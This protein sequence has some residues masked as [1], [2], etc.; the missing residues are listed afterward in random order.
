MKL[1]LLLSIG[2]I[3]QLNSCYAQLKGNTYQF[4]ELFGE[5]YFFN[6]DLSYK[7]LSNLKVPGFTEEQ[8]DHY[9]VKKIYNTQRDFDNNSYYLEWFE[10]EKYL[11]K[12]VDTIMPMSVKQKQPYNVFIERDIDYNAHA[13]GNG[14]VFANIG[15]LANCK[16]EAEL[17]YILSHEIGHSVFNHGYEINADLV[18]SYN[19]N[20]DAAMISSLNKIFDKSQFTELQSDSFAYKCVQK[21]S[22]NLGAARLALNIIGYSEFNSQFYI[23]KNHR[24]SYQSYMEKFSTHPS[25][26]KRYKLL[27]ANLKELKYVGKNYLID[28][29]YFNKVKKIAHEECKKISMETGDFNNSLKLAFIDYTQGDNSLKN[30]FYIFES[31]R[32]IMYLEPERSVKGFLAEDLQFSE[33]ENVNHSILKKP[34]VLFVDSMQYNKSKKHPLFTDETKPFNTY[35]EAYVYFIK[36][37][38]EKNFN[39]AFFSKALFCFSKKDDAGFK[40]NISKYLEKGGGLFTDFANNLNQFGFPYIKEGKTNI[41][42]DYS[43][44]FTVYDNY[45]H[46]LQ[47]IS[48]NKE[49]HELFK[50]DT[51]KVTLTLMSELLGTRPKLLYNYQKLKWNI[52]QLYDERDENRFYRKHYFSRDELSET[53]MKNKY[54]KNLMIYIPE[55]YKWFKENNLNGILYQKIKY[56]YLTVREP[57]EYHN[58]YSI[59]YLNFFDNRPYFGKCNRNG[60]LRKQKTTEMA[61]DA[62]EY[63]FYKE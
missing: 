42:I 21:A 51:A 38:E 15:L 24:G 16:N 44:N 37:S 2:I 3:F 8:L 35:E 20:D 52:A 6:P 29:V 5:S 23:S 56:E 32:R 27:A 33:F 18:S 34:E 12:I 45:L 4:P 55:W 39:E 7:K 28:S 1:K 62:R 53:K 26:E 43:T 50:G 63:L 54:N 59:S 30:L 58:Y 61:A 47:R 40:E 22:Y 60:V 19:R 36:L 57:V 9:K 14:F 46:S 13:L 31:I 41:L 25:F 11:S 10:L 48:N 49:V 17:A